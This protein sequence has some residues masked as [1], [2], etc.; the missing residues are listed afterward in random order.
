MPGEASS[1][2]FMTTA[3]D[4]A[5]AGQFGEAIKVLQEGLK[6]Y[7]KMASARV[8]LGEIYWT[9]GEPSLARVELEQVVKA[10]PDNFAAHRKLALIYR[11]MKAQDLA[12]R[13]CLAVLQA[14]PKD[15]EM[16]SLLAELQEGQP[17]EAA[18]AE[19]TAPPA[20]AARKAPK[21]VATEKEEQAAEP[22]V[23]EEEGPVEEGEEIESETLAELYIGQGHV[24][25]GLE[26]YRRLAAKDPDNERILSRIRELEEEQPP[27]AEAIVMQLD[28]TDAG[29]APPAAPRE[30]PAQTRRKAQVRRL[31][32]W[33]QVIRTRRRT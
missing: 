13:S 10:V 6:K 18:K 22:A 23:E 33:L 14:N 3:K 4:L 27:Q 1:R 30:T 2:A 21:K 19:A 12:V 20:K 29:Q 8:L 9:S 5:D 11:E 17:Q 28:E 7:P 24:Q 16:R 25:K 26:V 32:G 31:E 15:Q